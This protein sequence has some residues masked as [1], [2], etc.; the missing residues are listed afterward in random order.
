VRR[1]FLLSISVLAFAHSPAILAQSTGSCTVSQHR[2]LQDA[3][4]NQCGAAKACSGTDNQAALNSK[5][6]QISRC[7]D[8]RKN[9]NNT[10]Y[11]GG[12]RGHNTEIAQRQSSIDNC[13]KLQ[14]TAKP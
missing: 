1:I 7:I 8:A 12:D 2:T 6:G 5:I 9:I 4:E 10:C 11:A 13:K 3:V 14:A